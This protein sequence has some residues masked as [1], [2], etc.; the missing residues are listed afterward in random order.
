MH[1]RGVN[2]LFILRLLLPSMLVD[3]FSYFLSCHIITLICLILPLSIV[4]HIRSSFKSVALFFAGRSCL[5]S[6]YFLEIC[7]FHIRSSGRQRTPPRRLQEV[8]SRPM[9]RPHVGPPRRPGREGPP[10]LG[11]RVAQKILMWRSSR[12]VKVFSKARNESDA[13]RVERNRP[14]KE[15]VSEMNVVGAP[16][17]WFLL[18]L[19][20]PRRPC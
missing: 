10:K 19:P 9:K 20:P 14:R 3:I 12:N 18:D 16:A 8:G 5:G 17:R 2:V 6:K 13:V 1:E 15:E 7:E 11:P 4:D